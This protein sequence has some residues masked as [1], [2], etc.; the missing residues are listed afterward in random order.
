VDIDLTELFASLLVSAVGFVAFMY[1]KKQAR[2]PQMVSGLVLMIFPYF[3]SNWLLI[4]GIG[5]A[6]MAASWAAVRHGW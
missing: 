5:T 3:V 1:G 4:L 6:V 2:V